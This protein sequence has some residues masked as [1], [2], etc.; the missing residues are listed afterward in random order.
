MLNNLKL[1][2]IFIL[3]FI[4]VFIKS[5]KNFNLLPQQNNSEFNLS[6][7]HTFNMANSTTYFAF[8]YPWS[9][10]ECQEKLNDLDKKFSY[11]LDLEQ[12][13]FFILC[14]FK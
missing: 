4:I 3:H 9:Y 12:N 7:T 11:C 6:F 13:R 10:T 14:T 8:A 5:G 2:I 1:I